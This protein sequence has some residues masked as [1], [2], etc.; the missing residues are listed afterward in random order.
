MRKKTSLMTVTL[1]VLALAQLARAS[2]Y[3]FPY[4][5]VYDR[6]HKV[7]RPLQLYRYETKSTSYK[8]K[9]KYYYEVSKWWKK[10]NADLWYTKTQQYGSNIE[11]A[12]ISILYVRKMCTIDIGQVSDQGQPL[13][14]KCYAQEDWDMSNIGMV[15]IYPKGTLGSYFWTNQV[16]TKLPLEENA[17]GERQ[18]MTV[19]EWDGHY[20]ILSCF[21]SEIP[22]FMPYPLEFNQIQQKKVKL[23]KQKQEAL[24]DNGSSNKSGQKQSGSSLRHPMQDKRRNT[25]SEGDFK[26]HGMGSQNMSPNNSNQRDFKIPGLDAKDQKIA[27]RNPVNQQKDDK[28][29]KEDLL[30]ME[31]LQATLDQR[32]E[33]DR[34]ERSQRP[35]QI[36][37]LP[38]ITK[39]ELNQAMSGPPKQ[40]KKRKVQ[41]ITYGK[42][43]KKNKQ[44]ERQMLMI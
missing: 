27:I 21:F 15:G 33:D 2:E 3:L 41:I 42:K 40:K 20:P 30:E 8:Y 26:K 44:D 43:K 7:F 37:K 4:C 34:V 17:F 36:I 39:K 25:F 6:I 16:C 14:K 5:K 32:L 31:R 13:P 10:F 22:V 35:I 19:V 29:N 24:Q 1:T 11:A 12:T 28:F 23:E 9:K 38:G 18:L